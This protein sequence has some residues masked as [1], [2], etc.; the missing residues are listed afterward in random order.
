MSRRKLI[1]LTGP[2]GSGKTEVAN[3]LSNTRGFEQHM[4]AGPLKA[5]LCAMFGW[6]MDQWEDREW[7]ER[8]IPGLGFSPRRA[9]QTLGTEW[10]RGLNQDLWLLVAAMR[11]AKV[12]ETAAGLIVTDVRFDNE[13]EWVRASGGEVWRIE[14]PGLAPVEA[15]SSERGVD[16]KLWTHLIQNDGSKYDLSMAVIDVLS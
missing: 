12:P 15:H 10:G 2:A 13:A 16:P 11:W 1:G 4:L 7:K 14:R 6:T 8:V 5:G 9:A 3:F